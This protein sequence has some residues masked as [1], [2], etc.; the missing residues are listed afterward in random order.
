MDEA[1]NG[2]LDD[3]MN[4]ASASAYLKIQPDTLYRALTRGEIPYLRVGNN[5]R[6][7]KRTIDAIL[8]GELTLPR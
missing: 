2:E 5:I 3:I 7:S 8:R 4:V 6:V 1:K